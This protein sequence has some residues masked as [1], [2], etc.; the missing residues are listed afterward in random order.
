MMKKLVYII[1]VLLFCSVAFGSVDSINQHTTQTTRQSIEKI[2]AHTD[3][4]IDE[5]ARTG[6][7]LIN[8]AEKE[9]N[10]LMR[11]LSILFAIVLSSALI[12]ALAV[13]EMLKQY[14]WRR[15]QD[16]L[17]L[18]PLSAVDAEIRSFMTIEKDKG[19]GKRYIKKQLLSKKYDKKHI[20]KLINEV[21]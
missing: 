8:K 11:K 5:M 20:L 17:P 12:F 13:A 3:Q 9:I 10:G 15:K 4:K 18:K 2:N 16:Y 14:I 21:Y 7:E 6:D 19:Y 1:M